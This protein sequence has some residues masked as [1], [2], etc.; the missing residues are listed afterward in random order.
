MLEH[1][2][3]LR[4]DRAA[5]LDVVKYSCLNVTLVHSKIMF[6]RIGGPCV[7]KCPIPQQKHTLL[8]FTQLFTHNFLISDDLF[9]NNILQII[10]NIVANSDE[11]V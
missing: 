8:I 3:Y 5:N 11:S 10:Q 1:Q 4:S 9:I 7:R 6:F 2:V